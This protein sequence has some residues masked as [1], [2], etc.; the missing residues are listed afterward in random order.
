MN[1]PLTAETLALSNRASVTIERRVASRMRR[2]SRFTLGER[3]VETPV[4][5]RAPHS[6]PE[7]RKLTY[8]ARLAHLSARVREQVVAEY[9]A[10]NKAHA[11]SA[12]EGPAPAAPDTPTPAP[13][14]ASAPRAQRLVV[15]CAA[16]CGT[17]HP[18]QSIRPAL[19]TCRRGG[20]PAPKPTPE[21]AGVGVEPI[22]VGKP[23]GYFKEK[24]NRSPEKKARRRRLSCANS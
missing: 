7:W 3:V 9:V 17:F 1:P 4:K 12:E 20:S 8:D 16:G 11:P 18:A 22:I 14:P 10:E 24:I 6:V 5:L 23:S 13:A 21:R 19:V 15:S 2:L